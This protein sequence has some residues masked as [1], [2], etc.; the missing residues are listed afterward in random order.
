MSAPSKLLR[1]S[2]AVALSCAV[3]AS[4]FG[5][6]TPTGLWRTVDDVE[7]GRQKV[8]IRIVEADGVYSGRVEKVLDPRLVGKRCEKCTG[9][10]ANQ[11]LE[12]LQVL[13][14]MHKDGGKFGGGDVVDP[15]GG[16]TYRCQM[17]L[18][19]D[20]RHLEVRGYIG[21]ALLGRTQV[22]ERVE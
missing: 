6:A 1:R 19:T 8:L 12:G 4:A 22:W 16:G 17:Q 9:G 7:P 13:T 18:S 14:G 11:P 15:E 20:G 21:I 2:A 5:Q 3:M 10:R